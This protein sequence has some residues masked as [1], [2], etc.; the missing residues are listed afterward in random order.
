MT[1]PPTQDEVADAQATLVRNAQDVLDRARR[2]QRN[3]PSNE[4]IKLALDYLGR[5]FIGANWITPPPP[6]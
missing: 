4:D 2:G 5:T 1:E 3:P 6:P